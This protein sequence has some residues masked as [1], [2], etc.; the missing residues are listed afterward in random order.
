MAHFAEIDG[1]NVVLRVIVVSNDDEP[2]GENFCANLLGG[3]WLRTSYNTSGGIHL[4]GGTPLRMNYA[5]PGFTYDQARD[6]FIPPQPFKS[7]VLDDKTCIWNAPIARPDGDFQWNE[8][9]LSWI[10]S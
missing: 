9:S 7:W 2:D 8:P 4:F 5:G 10:K 6:A 3:T 1:N